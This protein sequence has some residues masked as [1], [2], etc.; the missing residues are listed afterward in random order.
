[1]GYSSLVDASPGHNLLSAATGEKMNAPK[2]FSVRR[3]RTAM[4]ELSCECGVTR[5]LAPSS[6]VLK[7]RLL[8]PEMTSCVSSTHAVKSLASRL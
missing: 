8:L 4:L 7:R 5:T 3:F 1:M 6:E 2:K